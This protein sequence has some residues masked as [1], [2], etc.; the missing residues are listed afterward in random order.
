[1]LLNVLTLLT[2]LTIS[3]VA[4][5]YSVSGLV[6]IFAAFPI[7]IIIMG[8]ALEVAKLVT[9]VWLHYHWKDAVWWLRSYL[10]SA[11][12]LLMIITSMGIFGFLSK[13]HVEQTA[14]SQES[15]A[16]I[17]R[18]EN[19][20]A[21]NE[22]IIARAEDRI[23]KAEEGGSNLDISIQKQ[24][25]KE[26][27]RIDLAYKRKAEI[28]KL[29]DKRVKP[30][31]E[32]IESISGV[33]EDLQTA[34]NA[35]D[36]K[37]A[38]GIVGTRTDGQYG[39]AT[40]QKVKEFREAEEAKRN[41]LLAEVDRIRSAKNDGEKEIADSNALIN[42][43]REKLGTT[44]SQE[45]V[46]GLIV[47]NQE[48]IKTA[49]A[50]L[51]GLFTQKFALQAENRKLEAEVGPIK[52]IAAFVYDQEPDQNLLEEAVTWVIILIIVVF[53]PLA[54]LLL[55]ASQYSFDRSRAMK[56]AKAVSDQT[57]H[58]IQDQK[59]SVTDMQR[60]I[61]KAQ[62]D[63]NQIFVDIQDQKKRILNQ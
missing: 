18:I 6:A 44:E 31:L 2:A 14:A 57:K 46:E 16:Q 60:D 22:S 1:M 33:L 20:I 32:Q 7:S 29:I 28:E 19:E 62:S 38:Q 11:V 47:E 5:Y 37:K 15:V 10:S 54:V 58:D 26:Q 48:K 52:Y 34:I 30:Y 27:E 24:I 61:D 8:T 43:L 42:R 23:K 39:P 21:R 9:V 55:I 3:A 45:D 4:I 49:N 13:S 51:D 12:A 50:E 53:D 40:A 17:K 36:I 56:K 41:E 35:G 25:D 63:L 59:S